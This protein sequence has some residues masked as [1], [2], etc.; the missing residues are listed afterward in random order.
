MLILKE[1]T[2]N[3]DLSQR[4]SDR[5]VDFSGVTGKDTALEM[6]P[7]TDRHRY[8]G[9]DAG[10]DNVFATKRPFCISR[11]ASGGKHD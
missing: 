2:T 10:E 5:K 7:V 9:L 4:D 6:I 8:L 1:M 11:N 3:L